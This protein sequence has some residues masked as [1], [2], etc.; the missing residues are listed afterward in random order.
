MKTR[1]LRK[2]IQDTLIVIMLALCVLGSGVTKDTPLDQIF[3]LMLAIG[4][5]FTV[6][7]R[8]GKWNS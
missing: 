8:Y 2:S 5:I 7:W 3:I 4:A 1:H 6:V